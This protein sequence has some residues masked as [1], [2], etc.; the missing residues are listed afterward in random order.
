[1][2]LM[3]TVAVRPGASE[4][5]PSQL[6]SALAAELPAGPLVVGSG[7]SADDI[8]PREALP[9]ALFLPHQMGAV[10]E[11][12]EYWPPPGVTARDAFDRVAAVAV[13]AGASV[14]AG[15]VM[16]ETV[17]KDYQ[18]TW[19]D[20]EPSSGVKMV[21]IGRRRPELT[22]EQFETH[23]REVHGPL[24]LTHHVGMWRY[25]QNLV[26]ERL[27]QARDDVDSM[28]ELHFRTVDDLV[29][30]L[31]DSPEGRKII[32]ADVMRFGGGGD[33]HFFEETILRGRGQRPD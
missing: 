23:W 1:V 19:P 27:G 3:V 12:V 9:R 13:A 15:Y 24:A 7:R 32:A 25:V 22:V 26:V 10:A 4:L 29:H 11:L 5:G 33:T 18:Q 31:Y 28:A 17:V 30:R 14:V 6:G 20:G 8:R 2:K 16:R 21:S